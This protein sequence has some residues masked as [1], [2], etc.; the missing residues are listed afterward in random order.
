M[1]AP[2]P[3]SGPVASGPTPHPTEPTATTSPATA[4]APPPPGDPFDIALVGDTGYSNQYDQ[5]FQ[6]VIED[7]NRHQLG[8][9]VHDGDIK[10]PPDARVNPDRV[11]EDSRYVQVRG[12]FKEVKAPFVY[13][14]G[15][16]EWMDCADP[17]GRLAFLRNTF[18]PNDQSLGERTL[19]VTN[20]RA[21]GYPENARW[22]LGGVVFAT[23]N[24]PG[25][26]DNI[27]EP[28][29]SGPRREANRAW[30]EAAFEAAEATNA[31]ALMIIWQ[32]NPFYDMFD[33]V[34]SYLTQELKSRA[35]AFGKPVVLVH[36]DTHAYKIDH[37]W[38]DVPHFT[39][40][41]T[42]ALV[43]PTSWVRA[44]VDPAAPGVFTFHDEVAG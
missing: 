13:T 32:A 1:G 24:V 29:E 5:Q 40:V 19:T 14:P 30:L 9:V 35:V 43:D 8:F 33:H 41:E 12:W 28:G 36:G 21:R 34:F 16:N 25:P 42:H 37:P 3:A 22:S 23:L 26:N 4:P 6:R 39:R 18:F 15:D 7:M 27:P 17:A 44:T 20:Q 11:C 2:R 31:P 10:A 38:P